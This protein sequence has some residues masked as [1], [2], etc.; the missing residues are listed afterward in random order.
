M[1]CIGG[2]LCVC[3]FQTTVA[4]LQTVC[5]LKLHVLTSVEGADKAHQFSHRLSTN[6]CC[7]A[8][9]TSCSVPPECMCG[10]VPHFVGK[11]A[12]RGLTKNFSAFVG[13]EG[14][15]FPNRRFW[16]TKTLPSAQQLLPTGISYIYIY[17]L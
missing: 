11:I 7:P 16:V 4:S 8:P 17:M 5:G 2:N 3:G 10:D 13:S 12:K 15:G 1:G 9:R 6:I 14:G